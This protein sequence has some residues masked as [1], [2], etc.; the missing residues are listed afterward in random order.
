MTIT[1]I[2][3]YI[4]SRN[5]RETLDNMAIE[6]DMI[7]KQHDKHIIAI[8]QLLKEKNALLPVNKREK[9]ATL[10][11]DIAARYKCNPRTIYKIIKRGGK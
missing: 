7:R 4:D 2:K 6:R 11:N 10:I 5:Y 8:L 9:V 1:D 3:E